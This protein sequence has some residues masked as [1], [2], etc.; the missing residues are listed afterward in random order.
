MIFTSIFVVIIIYN[1]LK[2]RSFK[3]IELLQGSNVGEREPKAKWL[4]AILGLICLLVGYYLAIT[5]ENPIQ[6]LTTFFVAVLFVIAGT[7][8]LF[9]SGSIALLKILKRNKK[10]YYHKT[11]FIT[12]S[13]MMY[14]MK[15]NAVGLANICILSTAVLVVLSSTVSLYIGID[16][17]MRTRYPSDVITNYLYS[18]E[19]DAAENLH[20]N[21]DNNL[22]EETMLDH[23][24]RYGVELK[25]IQSYYTMSTVGNIVEEQF[26]PSIYG[27]QDKVYLKAMTIEDYNSIAGENGGVDKLDQNEAYLFSSDSSYDSIKNIA[28]ANETFQVSPDSQSMKLNDELA[29]KLGEINNTILLVVPDFDKLTLIRDAVNG[30][31]QNSGIS[32]INHIRYN[33][34]FNLD[35]DLTAKEDFSKTLRDKLN[36]AGIPHVSTVENIFTTRQEFIGIYGSLFFVGIFVGTLFL[37]TTVMIIYYKQ[38]SEGYEDRDRFAIMQKVGMSKEDVKHVIKNQILMVF[39]LPIVL[40]VVHIAFAFDIIRKLLVILNLTNVKLFVG[41]TVGTI[42]VFVIIY[43]I[44]YKLTARA[45][46]RLINSQE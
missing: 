37:L 32:G 1:N 33:Y 19:E 39:Y 30:M 6:A 8:L 41:C 31:N 27:I 20:Y 13:G 3:P 9:M 24:D 44:V 14:R 4:L 7:Y 34:E 15:Q 29:K 38:I 21:Y 11:H 35:G 46:Y 18:P 16:D 10:F 5:T 42:F 40:A 28:F 22:I 12:I 36:G 26:T 2:L 23:A 25:D 17:V 43:G 45:Y